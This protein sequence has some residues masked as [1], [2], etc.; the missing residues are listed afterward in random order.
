[1]SREKTNKVKLNGI[2]PEGL[3]S[4]GKAGAKIGKTGRWVRQNL[5]KF[6][7]CKE[8]AASPAVGGIAYMITGSDLIAVYNQLY[9]KVPTHA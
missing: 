9:G 8:V 2:D 4:T 5:D 1:M 6:P 7:N 3:Y